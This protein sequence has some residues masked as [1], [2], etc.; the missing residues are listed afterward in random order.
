MVLK[1]LTKKIQT[2]GRQKRKQKELELFAAQIAWQQDSGVI[3]YAHKKEKRTLR[4]KT[5]KDI[6]S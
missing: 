3:T 6:S 2:V 4:K 1:V 5:F